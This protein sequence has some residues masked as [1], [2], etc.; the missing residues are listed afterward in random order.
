MCWTSGR[1]ALKSWLGPGP[2]PLQVGVRGTEDGASARTSFVT[3][4]RIATHHGRRMLGHSI[5]KPEHNLD[6]E[7]AA[8]G[9]CGELRHGL[10]YGIDSYRG[11][12]RSGIL[13]NDHTLP[14]RQV[15][16]LSPFAHHKRDEDSDYS[17]SGS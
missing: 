12:T 1:S 6:F 8:C 5:G 13:P 2:R 3:E 17:P 11:R 16:K 10:L 15:R 4:S 7:P 9:N 14:H